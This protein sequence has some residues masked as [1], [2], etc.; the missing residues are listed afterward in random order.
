MFKGL[1]FQTFKILKNNVCGASVLSYNGCVAPVLG[2][3]G[4]GAPVLG[5]NGC[6]APVF[7]YNGCG[8]RMLGNNAGVYILLIFIFPINLI[9]FSL[10]LEYYK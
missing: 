5:N 2:N 9:I 10:N 3:N 4:C 7:G 6:G 1:S 8:A